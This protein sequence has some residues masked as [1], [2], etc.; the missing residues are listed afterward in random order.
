MAAL[1][2]RDVL[3]DDLV[4]DRGDLP[5]DHR[6]A[7]VEVEVVPSQAEALA[8]PASGGGEEDPRRQ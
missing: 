1:G 8:A 2:L 3:D 7:G 4:V 6:G 5:R